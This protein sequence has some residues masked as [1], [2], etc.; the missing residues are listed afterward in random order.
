M[1]TRI[2]LVMAAG[3]LLFTA[4]LAQTPTPPRQA[5]AAPAAAGGGAE[6]KIAIV[7]F[8]AFREGIQEMKTKMDALNTEFDPKNKE[9]QDL[10]EKIA[11]LKKQI[12]TQG[13]TVTPAVRNQWMEQGAQ[14]EKDLKRKTE[15]YEALANKRLSEVGGPIQEKILKFLDQYAAQRGITMV[16]EGSAVQQNGLLLYAAEATNITKDFMDEYNK[17]NPVAAA[18][19]PAAPKK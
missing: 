7:F 12:E 19:P 2:L 5:A 3:G 18:A 16:L 13:A 9:L 6:G 10:Q 14:L 15:D 1:I 4:A 8:G 17:A 11:N